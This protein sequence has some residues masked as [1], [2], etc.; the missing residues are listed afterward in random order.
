M[1]ENSL[2]RDGAMPADSE[3]DV[4]NDSLIFKDS[5]PAP[6]PLSNPLPTH[7]L[8]SYHYKFLKELQAD[9]QKF[10]ASASFYVTRI[11][12]INLVKDFSYSIV[13][14]GC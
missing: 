8:S 11:H 5:K 9:L 14:F 4:D 12:F 3:I 13:I 2:P 10:T 1:A 6:E 7:K